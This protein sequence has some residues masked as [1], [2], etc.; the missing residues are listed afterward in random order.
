MRFVLVLVVLF[1]LSEGREYLGELSTL[2]HDVSGSVYAISCNKLVIE[3]FNYDGLGPAVFAYLGK[4]PPAGPNADSA[5]VDATVMH[6]GQTFMQ[7]VRGITYSDET[8]LLT[9]PES[10]GIN[11]INWLSIWCKSVTADFGNINF[12]SIRQQTQQICERKVFCQNLREGYDVCWSVNSTSANAEITLC[13][14]NRPNNYFMG[15]GISSLPTTTIMFNADPALCWRDDDGTWTVQDYYLSAYAQCGVSQGTVL[16]VCMDTRYDGGVDNLN[17]TSGGEQDGVSWCTYNRP[18]QSPDLAH[19]NNI[20]LTGPQ[21]VVWAM[22]PV[23]QGVVFQHPAGFRPVS[24]ILIDFANGTGADECD[25]AFTQGCCRDRYRVDSTEP[26][27]P[28]TTPPPPSCEPCRDRRNKVGKRRRFVFTI[29]TDGGPC[30]YERLTNLNFSWGIAWYVDGCLVPDL[31]VKR[32]KKYTFCVLGGNDPAVPSDYH[33]L[34]I[35]SSPE[36]GYF[37]KLFTGQRTNETIYAGIDRNNNALFTG[38]LVSHS[39]DDIKRCCTR[40][41]PSCPDGASMY[42]WKVRR[43]TPDVVYYQCGTH[44]Y[45]GSKITVTD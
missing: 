35:T 8:I 32:G 11:E 31:T 26:T 42:T 34:Y 44:V 2:A 18:L 36:G 9:L 10:Y 24:N 1:A 13:S 5:G 39:D 15:F 38:P 17:M 30:G 33:P 40:R 25:G 37:Q 6:G 43:N 19:D 28:P 41:K 21:A 3:H 16:G 7:F 14:N 23:V 22:G 12:G 27:I 29:G 4:N 45:L 20:T